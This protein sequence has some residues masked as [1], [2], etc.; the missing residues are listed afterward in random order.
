MRWYSQ[1]DATTAPEAR[2]RSKV[3]PPQ[4]TCASCGGK[5]VYN[6]F[7][8][9]GTCNAATKSGSFKSVKREWGNEY[10]W[11]ARMWAGAL[12]AGRYGY[13]AVVDTD[14]NLSIVLCKTCS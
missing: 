14:D 5:R 13:A 3:Q 4:A 1:P 10:A 2:T 7:D 11:N 6:S 12:S 8:G 9:R